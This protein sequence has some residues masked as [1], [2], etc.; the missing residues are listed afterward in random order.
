MV[1][2][3]NVE[4]FLNNQLPLI[5]VRSPAEYKKG[6]IPEA[7]NIPVFTDE[8]RAHI[9]TV[10]SNVSPEKATELAYMYV[11][12]KMESFI[13]K[14]EETATGRKVAVHCWRGGMRSR[15]FAEFLVNNGF[16]E[17]SVIEGGYKAY[18]NFVLKTFEQPFILKVVGGYTGSGK[19]QIIRQLQNKGHQVIDLEAMANHKGSAFGHIGQSEQPTTEQFENNLFHK[20]QKLDTSNPVW[21]ED[22]SRNI[23]GINIPDA[24]YQQMQNSPLFF[25]D[26]PKEIRAKHLVDEYSVHDPGQLAESIQRIN[27][28]LGGLNTS[29]ALSLLKENKYF[30]AAVITLG[31]YDK[32]YLKALR[33]RNQDTIIGIKADDIHPA[34][35]AETILKIDHIYDR[36]KV[37]PI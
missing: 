31:Y 29:H 21:L 5:D 23:G 26:I 37:N 13:G 2:Y 32:S 14:A 3:I 35:N 30:E 19:T 34:E 12:P 9:G 17:I 25:I 33:Y 6:H 27:R 1:S 8:E 28:R 10:Y 24:F 18:R 22:E 36:T 11:K 16:Q 20:I 15:L 7:F 4:R